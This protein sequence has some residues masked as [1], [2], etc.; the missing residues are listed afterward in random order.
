MRRQNRPHFQLLGPSLHQMVDDSRLALGHHSPR[1][2][3][4]R[5]KPAMVLGAL[6]ELYQI[7]IRQL[8]PRSGVADSIADNTASGGVRIHPR[9]RHRPYWELLNSTAI[10]LQK[11]VSTT[12]APNRRSSAATRLLYRPIVQHKLQLRR[13]QRRAS[14]VAPRP[15]Y[16]Q[17]VDQRRIHLPPS[18]RHRRRSI[19]SSKLSDRRICRFLF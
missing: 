3:I 6:D 2:F 4:E 12:I 9:S 18:R 14:P 17:L 11:H 16:C 1:S 7:S 8:V 5:M 13:P 10:R 15:I 19:I